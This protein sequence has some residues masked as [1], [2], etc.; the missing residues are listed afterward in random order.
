MMVIESVNSDAIKALSAASSKNDRCT[1]G[2]EIFK[3]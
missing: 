2:H 3:E 1:T